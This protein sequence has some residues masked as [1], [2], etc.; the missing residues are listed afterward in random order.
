MCA[1]SQQILGE[2]N[3]LQ[4]RKIQ[5]FLHHQIHDLKQGSHKGSRL[6]KPT[7]FDTFR[8]IWKKSR[9]RSNRENFYLATQAAN[10]APIPKTLVEYFRPL[11]IENIC[12]LRLAAFKRSFWKFHLSW[13]S[14]IE[15]KS[16][17]YCQITTLRDRNR[18]T[19]FPAFK[20]HFDKHI[21]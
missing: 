21:D 10:V 18:E 4:F 8:I 19:I 13:D 16:D 17:F 1:K 11:N 3:S 9:N 5:S 20:A 7:L 2:V 14:I 6:E 12:W 15:I